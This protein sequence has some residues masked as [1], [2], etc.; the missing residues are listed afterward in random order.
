M[1]PATPEPF[2]HRRRS[3]AGCLCCGSGRLTR[4]VQLVSGFLAERAWQGRPELTELVRCEDC[5][6]RFFERG[7][8][9]EEVTRYYL[10]YR[11]A[12][13]Q[14]NRQAWEPFYTPQ[15]HAALVAWSDALVRRENIRH[16]LESAA[17]PTHFLSVLDHGGSHGHM[18]S[19][20]DAKRKA[21]FD[22]AANIPVAG[23]EAFSN[24]PG[25]PI[26]WSLILS[27][28]VLEHISQPAA[29]LRHLHGL[30]ADD[31]W[32][33]VEVPN[34]HWRS[35]PGGDGLRKLLIKALMYWRPLLI[36]ADVFCTACR[37]K[38]GRLPPLG[39]IAMREHL[40]YYTAESLT[41]VLVG[42]GFRVKA[43]GIDNGGQLFA[44][45]RKFATA[46]A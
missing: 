16:S 36:A 11:N 40:N 2:D 22:P 46:D 10:G 31:G 15:R 26:G 37:I 8:D 44:V 39:F 6:L 24:A 5:G 27:C 9:E 21:V 43:C 7:L 23:V 20:I 14:R 32:L 35:A 19:S 17:A 34:E 4:E 38:F 13:Y 30:L 33:Y 18:L 42:N 28:Q 41:A 3:A 1:A 25:L 29:Y 45:A 12:S